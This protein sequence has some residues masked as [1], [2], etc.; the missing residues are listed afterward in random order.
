MILKN[1]VIYTNSKG[2]KESFMWLEWILKQK[3]KKVVMS[4]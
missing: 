4:I 2:K 1:K 3:N